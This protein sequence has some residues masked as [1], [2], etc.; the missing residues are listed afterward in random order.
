MNNRQRLESIEILLQRLEAAVVVRDLG[1]AH[2]ADAYDG[3]RKQIIQSGKNHRMH[4]A[5]LLSLADSMERGADLQLIRDRV[6]DFLNELGVERFSDIS[7]VEL[8][9]V[10]EGEGSALECIEPAIIEKLDNGGI[11]PIRLGKARRVAGPEPTNETPPTEDPHSNQIVLETQR[12][13]PQQRRFVPIWIATI[14][15]AFVFGLLI[16]QCGGG[17]SDNETPDTLDLVVTTEQIISSTSSDVISTTTSTNFGTTSD[18]GP[19]TSAI[20]GE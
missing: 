10:T 19:S 13:E 6:N 11:S 18:S 15:L 14:A 12:Q 20:G 17:S 1:N 5:H 16:S 9:E 7:L 3:L 2:S 4:V 8:F